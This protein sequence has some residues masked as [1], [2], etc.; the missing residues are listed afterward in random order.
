MVLLA[1]GLPLLTA[2]VGTPAEEKAPPEPSGAGAPAATRVLE[3][4]TEA[5]GFRVRD[6]AG[7]E[8]SFEVE[9]QRFPYLLV[10]WSVFCE[11]CR[12]QLTADQALYDK[13]RDAGLR[14]AAVGLDGEPLRNV[15]AGFVRQEGYTFQVLLD[16]LDDRQMFKTADAYGVAGMPSTFLIDRGGRIAFSRV[17][18]VKTEELEKALQP[19]LRP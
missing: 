2:P 5:P 10:F 1:V 3:P 9:N 11:P 6:T 8:V 7:A 19:L 12:L 13:Y 17:G 15:V 16:D 14:V 18:L 4:G